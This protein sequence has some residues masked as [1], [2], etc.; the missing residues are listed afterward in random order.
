M[1]NFVI[2]TATR[3]ACQFLDD[4]IVNYN[5]MKVPFTQ[6]PEFIPIN[7]M[8]TNE[9]GEIIGGILGLV[10]C[11]H[12]LYVDVLWVDE[13]HRGLNLGHTLLETL[14]TEAKTLGAKLVHLDTFDFQ[15]KDF[16]LKE[17]YR[18]FGELENCPEG[19]TRYYMSKML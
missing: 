9:D 7:K 18:I 17:G 6:D 19:H 1:K 16:Y 13:R 8:A 14:E 5:A 15:A 2:E 3:E 4:Q 11:W 12:V 10:Y